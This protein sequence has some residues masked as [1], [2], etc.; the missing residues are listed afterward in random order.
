MKKCKEFVKLLLE[1]GADPNTQNRVT[2]MP[3]LQ[4]TAGSGNFE[5]LLVLLEKK[6]IDTDLKD[7]EMRR[8]LHWLASVSER[9]P[10][11]KEK[12]EK[13]LKLHLKSNYIR[14]KDVDDRDSSGNTAV[15]IAV[16]GGFRDRAK[17]LLSKGADFRVLGIG[18]KILLL[19]SVSIVEQILDDCLQVNKKLLKS[20]DLQLTLNCQSSVKIVPRIV[21]SKIHRD[22]LTHPIMPTFLSLKWQ[23]VRLIFFLDMALYAIFLCLLTKYILRSE[24]YNTVNDGGAVNNTTDPFSFNGSNTTS[25]MNNSNFTSQ[26]T[27]SASISWRGF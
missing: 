10:G 11:D 6:G 5:V 1:N 7:N 19:D 25:D 23:K 27:T 9:K 15:Y 12:I 26:P 13:C 3:L 18:S 8:I 16:E 2:G 4:A 20:K 14:K 17:L 24:P 21:E 22:L